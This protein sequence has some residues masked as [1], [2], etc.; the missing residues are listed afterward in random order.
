[1]L[2]EYSCFR[3]SDRGCGLQGRDDDGVHA[4]LFRDRACDHAC[5][6]ACGH[7]HA[8]DRVYGHVC[9]HAH[10]RDRAHGHVCA[11]HHVCGRDRHG[12]HGRGHVRDDRGHDRDD[13]AFPRRAYPLLQYPYACVGGHARDYARGRD[14]AFHALRY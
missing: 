4:L 7:V 11:L 12:D 5:G 9:D 10:A 3:E 1:M 2:L 14:A 8:R 13:H 6:R